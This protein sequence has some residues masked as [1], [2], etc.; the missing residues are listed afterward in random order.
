MEKL[1]RT[2]KKVQPEKKKRPGRPPIDFKVRYL[3]YKDLEELGICE[4]R[5]S[6]RRWIARDL[7]PAPILLSPNC[8][9]WRSDEVNAFLESRKT[10]NYKDAS[11]NRGKVG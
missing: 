5:M 1:K 8:V 4:N 10:R 7:F 3:R 6:L 11:Y 2:T 9:A